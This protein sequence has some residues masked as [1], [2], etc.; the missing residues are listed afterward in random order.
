MPKSQDS[1]EMSDA[2]GSWCNFG[3]CWRAPFSLVSA[4][5]SQAEPASLITRQSKLT[6]LGTSRQ[7]QKFLGLTRNIPAIV[8]IVVGGIMLLY[9]GTLHFLHD[10]IKCLCALLHDAVKPGSLG[11]AQIRDFQSLFHV[12]R[13]LVRELRLLLQC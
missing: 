4:Q 10:P 13:D 5:W 6:L 11:N 1:T 12:V 9:V 7:G 8:L 2:E 3:D